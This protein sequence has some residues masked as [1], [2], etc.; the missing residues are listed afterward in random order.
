MPTEDV[1]VSGQAPTGNTISN[2]SDFNEVIDVPAGEIWYVEK[3]IWD[4]DQTNTNAPDSV[5]FGITSA[6]SFDNVRDGI[7]SV[8]RKETVN[9]VNDSGSLQLD[10]YAYGDDRIGVA[11]ETGSSSSP[12]YRVGLRRVV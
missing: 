12:Y 1:S 4:V 9:T 3:L 5:E 6:S 8:S 10:E 2:E 7:S 11:F